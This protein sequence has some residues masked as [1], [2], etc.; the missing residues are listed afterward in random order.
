MISYKNKEVGDILCML[1]Y[2]KSQKLHGQINQNMTF[3]SCI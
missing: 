2:S 1:I 3:M